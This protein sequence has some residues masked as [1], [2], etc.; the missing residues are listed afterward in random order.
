MLSTAILN[1]ML[2]MSSEIS[3]IKIILPL[4]LYAMGTALAIPGLSIL[5]MDCFPHNRGT[6]AAVQS[7]VQVLFSALAASLLVPLLSASP[8][9]YALTQMA[10]IVLAIIFWLSGITPKRS[11]IKPE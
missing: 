9:H 7:F 6:A 3:A 8:L 11:L 1:V 5:A 2:M 4:A 10:C